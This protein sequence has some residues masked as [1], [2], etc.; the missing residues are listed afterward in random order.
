MRF[1]AKR[2]EHYGLPAHSDGGER[3]PYDTDHCDRR[4]TG[5]E[6]ATRPADR[7]TAFRNHA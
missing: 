7:V 3:V 1:T 5:G 4:T 6:Q 2:P